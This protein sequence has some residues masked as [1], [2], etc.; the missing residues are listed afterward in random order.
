M[1]DVAAALAPPGNHQDTVTQ[2]QVRACI[3]SA[4]QDLE[5][6]DLVGVTLD[7]IELLQL[8]LLTGMANIRRD[9]AL[10]VLTSGVSHAQLAEYSNTTVAAINR[11]STEGRQRVRWSREKEAL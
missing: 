9:A 2:A 6:I 3:V 1:V 11:L 4:L 7:I 5:P 8:Q 10:E